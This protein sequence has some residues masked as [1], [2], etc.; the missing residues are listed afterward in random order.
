M[1]TISYVYHIHVYNTCNRG[2]DQRTGDIL[3]STKVVAT[4]PATGAKT[5]ELARS[6]SPSALI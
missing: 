1:H 6:L 5:E 4:I 2:E 3:Y